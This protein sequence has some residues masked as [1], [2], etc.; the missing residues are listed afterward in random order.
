M[1]L[2]QFVEDRGQQAEYLLSLADAE[3]LPHS[4]IMYTIDG[5]VVPQVIADAYDEADVET[6]TG[7]GT[8]KVIN[9]GTNLNASRQDAA[10]AYWKFAAGV[11]T[12]VDHVNITNGR[13]GD[14]VFVASA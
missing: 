14:L 6:Y 8:I 1:A 7:S 10:V 4:D 5:F 13:K 2:I 9:A 11:D 3:G 12:G